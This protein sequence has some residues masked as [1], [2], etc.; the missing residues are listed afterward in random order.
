MP[1]AAAVPVPF[2][3]PEEQLRGPEDSISTSQPQGTPSPEHPQRNAEDPNDDHSDT[4]DALEALA[5]PYEYQPV[6][7]SFSCLGPLSADTQVFRMRNVCGQVI[8]VRDAAGQLILKASGQFKPVGYRF[9]FVDVTQRVAFSVSTLES[10]GREVFEFIGPGKTTIASATCKRFRPQTK[11]RVCAGTAK[12]DNPVE[13][14][15]RTAAPRRGFKRSPTFSVVHATGLTRRTQT[16]VFK[17]TPSPRRTR[18][19]LP[20]RWTPT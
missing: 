1:V 19:R 14:E 7:F 12:S 13:V 15:C 4:V 11:V 20:G 9:E 3:G 5:T 17:L 10:Q 2:A 16:Q 18:P 8:E 6:H